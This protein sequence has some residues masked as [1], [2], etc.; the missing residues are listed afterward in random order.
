MKKAYTFLLILLINCTL[1]GQNNKVE[2]PPIFLNSLLV[3]TKLINGLDV[4]TYNYKNK[5]IE[6]KK[7]VIYLITKDKKKLHNKTNDFI[8]E[9]SDFTYGKQTGY[10]S[11]GYF[12]KGYKNGLWKTTY[13][14]HLV[15][16]INYNNGLIIG[17][18]RV[19]NTEGDLLY[20]TTFGAQGNGKFKD[21]N[22]KTG[23]LKQEGNYEN[24]KKEGEWC[25]Y[26]EQGNTKEIIHYKN[27]T[28]IKK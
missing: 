22:Y 25:D 26:D 9:K 8:R 18:Y 28:P 2:A 21:Y 15:Q 17:K 1:F 3:K 27:G 20:K 16:S 19:Y 14:K 4:H 7:Y 5:D 13:K 10:T 6:D 24:G 11:I 12:S 23:V